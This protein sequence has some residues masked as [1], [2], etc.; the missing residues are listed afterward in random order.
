MASEMKTLEQVIETLRRMQPELQRRYSILEMG[1]F[2]SFV[3]GQQTEESDLDI[4]VS[5]GES[6]GLMSLASLQQELT[7]ALGLR[8]DLIPKPSLQRRIGRRILAE[9]VML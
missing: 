5:V 6:I 8:V 2:G 4:L 7:D 9:A 1:I 3:R